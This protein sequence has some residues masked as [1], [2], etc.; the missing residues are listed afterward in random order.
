MSSA[1]PHVDVLIV[2]AGISG[3][4]AAVHLQRECPGKTFTI[5]EGRANI[6][7]TWDLF[8]YPGIRSDSDMYTLGFS[9]KPWTQPKAIADGPSIKQYLR[10]TVDEHNLEPHIQFQTKVQ[11]AEWDSATANWTV[12][13]NSETGPQVMSA[14][15]VFMCGGYYRYDQG[16]TPQFAGMEDFAGLILHPQ[17]WPETLDYTGKR[18]VVI[19]SGATAVTMVPAMAD[20]GAAH[21]TM[22]QRS[23]SY[24]VTRPSSDAI[25]DHLRKRFPAKAAYSLVRQKNVRM[26][27]F[28]YKMAKTKPETVKAKFAE[29]IQKELP[30][31]DKAHFTPTYNPWDQRVCLVPDGDLFRNI[32]DSKVDIVTAHIDRFT[33]TGIKLADGREIPA[34]IIVTATGLNLQMLGG[35][36]TIVDGQT[37][38]PGDAVLHKGVM[39]SGVPNYAMWFGY[40]NASWT[41]KADLTSAYMC[42]VLR[43]MDANGHS[44]VVPDSDA[45]GVETFVDFSSGYFQRSQHLLPKQG[46]AHPWRLNQN[47]FQDIKLLRKGKID[48]EGLAFSKKPVGVS[49]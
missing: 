33:T 35:I 41:L 19:G 17:H 39:L 23:P 13:L 44:T 49:R 2:G 5:I 24:M 27:A 7:G 25:A 42:R 37:V 26:G 46:K 4:G 8:R 40:T 15:F 47:Y 1:L 43:F 9:F 6:G 16:Y 38:V 10:E 18:I 3:I 34:D 28:F 20:K 12:T 21:V 29:G 45:P 22:L 31:Y 14:S 32:R 36:E 30:D 48:D 11:K